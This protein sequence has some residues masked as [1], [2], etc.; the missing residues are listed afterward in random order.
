MGSC[1]S[2]V[3]THDATCHVCAGALLLCCGTMFSDTKITRSRQVPMTRT[4][5]NVTKAGRWR[6]SPNLRRSKVPL[7]RRFLLN[8]GSPSFALLPPNANV[9]AL[10]WKSDAALGFSTI[11]QVGVILTLYS[12]CVLFYVPGTDGSTGAEFGRD[13]QAGATAENNAPPLRGATC[14][15]G[16]LCDDCTVV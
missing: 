5:T 6:R 3:R 9:A 14:N 16:M 7:S 10:I 15:C 11:S 12:G 8:P 4:R 1:R 2:K 13:G